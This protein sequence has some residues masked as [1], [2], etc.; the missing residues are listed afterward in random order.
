VKADLERQIDLSFL[1]TDEELIAFLEMKLADLKKQ[2][3][4]H[5]KA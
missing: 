3:T 5:V 1:E 2:R 4:K